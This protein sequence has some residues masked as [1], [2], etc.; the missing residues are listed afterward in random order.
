VRLHDAVP[1]Y[2]L[3]RL[4]IVVCG[5]VPV[6]GLLGPAVAFVGGGLLLSLWVDGGT[7]PNHLEPTDRCAFGNDRCAFVYIVLAWS[8]R[9]PDL[10]TFVLRCMCPRSPHTPRVS[11]SPHPCS[12]A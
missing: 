9:P 4:H 11:F 8:V 10:N 12:L 1:A 2:S 7:A 3:P 5:A 6:G